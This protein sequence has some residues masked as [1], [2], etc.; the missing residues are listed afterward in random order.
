MRKLFYAIGA[1]ICLAASNV[2][3]AAVC[4]NMNI[5]NY[6]GGTVYPGGSATVHGPFKA[7][8][9]YE[10]AIFK[11]EDLSGNFPTNTI[12][13]TIEMKSGYSW[14]PVYQ[15]VSRS[16]RSHTIRYAVSS[17]NEYRYRIENIGTSTI[18]NWSM[19]GRIPTAYIPY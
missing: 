14:T 3:S 7:P 12:L 16:A 4:Y 11:F 13:H 6:S 9:P 1:A 19:E 15:A 2:A 17:P 8:C 5:Y 10:I 18:M